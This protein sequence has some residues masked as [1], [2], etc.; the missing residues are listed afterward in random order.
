MNVGRDHISINYHQ[1]A[2]CI[3]WKDATI[4]IFPFKC[5]YQLHPRYLYVY[6]YI[7]VYIRIPIDILG[8]YPN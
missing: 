2:K 8:F 1:E 6:I 3:G 4:D 7:Y 5:G